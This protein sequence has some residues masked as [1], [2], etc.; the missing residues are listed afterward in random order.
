MVVDYPI[1]PKP[2]RVQYHQ[3]F[4]MG[5]F[6]DEFSF[7][8]CIVCGWIDCRFKILNLDLVQKLSWILFKSTWLAGCRLFEVDRESEKMYNLGDM[9]D[10]IRVES[11]VQVFDS[12][13]S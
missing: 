9:F 11:L 5:C 13:G 10:R 1:Q 4:G 12:D 8:F 7:F 2:S 6:G 3:L